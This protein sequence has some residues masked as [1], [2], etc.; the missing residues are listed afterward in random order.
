[1]TIHS[2]GRLQRKQNDY[3]QDHAKSFDGNGGNAS[4]TVYGS[5]IR[6]IPYTFSGK[7]NRR[8]RR[9]FRALL[10]RAQGENV[11]VYFTLLKEE[12]CDYKTNGSFHGGNIP[13][14]SFTTS[15]N[16]YE[17]PSR[18]LTVKVNETGNVCDSESDATGLAGVRLFRFQF[19]KMI[20]SALINSNLAN[21]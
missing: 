5:P 13:T 15:T 4:Q 18:F 21:Q 8:K 11:A 20:T 7:C 16:F 1:M 14:I 17:S 2:Q 19:G 10:T 3:V 6:H 12:V 9:D